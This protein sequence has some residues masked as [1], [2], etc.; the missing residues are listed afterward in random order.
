MEATAVKYSLVHYDVKDGEKK[1]HDVYQVIYKHLFKVA[2]Q[3]SGSVYYFNAE[4]E[5]LVDVAFSKVNEELRRKNKREVHYG[6][7]PVDKEGWEAAAEWTKK[8]LREKAQH[9]AASLLDSISK[10]DE[11]FHK[12]IDDPNKHIAKKRARI[13]R[14]K[15][16]L[17]EAQGLATIFAVEGDVEDALKA[18]ELV[19]DAQREL[20]GDLK[21]ELER[22]GE[23]V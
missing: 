9:V 7:V 17:E 16:Q 18:S 6:V 8:S 19:I 11:K 14:A 2:V 4:K 15:R 23:L 5:H 20:F 12:L 1:N 13:S 10:L 21:D 3:L 22:K